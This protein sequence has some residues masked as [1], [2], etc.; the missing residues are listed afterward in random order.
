MLGGARSVDLLQ[1][2]SFLLQLLVPTMVLARHVSRASRPWLRA[3]AGFACSGI[4][5]WLLN[6]LFALATDL[7]NPLL[8]LV[9][10]LL[11]F[12]SVVA[13]CWLAL[14]A[15]AST[16]LF[17]ACSGYALQNIAHYVFVM[18]LLKSGLG[19]SDDLLEAVAFVG[20]YGCAF[21][22]LRRPTASHVEA[23]EARRIFSA[24]LLTLFFTVVLSS[25]VPLSADVDILY[26]LYSVGAGVLILFMQ[27]GLLDTADATSERDVFRSELE[28]EARRHKLAM[29]SVSL[30]DK[31]CHDLK[32]LVFL[33]S[34]KGVNDESVAEACAAIDAYDSLPTT[35]DPNLDLVLAEK[36]LVCSGRGIDLS[37]MVDGS[38][39]S[40]LR[41][42]DLWGLFGSVFD[43]SLG[44]LAVDDAEPWLYVRGASREGAANLHVE[45]P[46]RPEAHPDRFAAY[47][48]V[49]AL[50]HGY[51]GVAALT[52]E[53]GLATLDVLLL[54]GGAPSSAA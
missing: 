53:G 19:L 7:D 21:V 32:H 14:D 41:V 23:I 49:R 20:T 45:W 28:L 39:F 46:C 17:F 22:A 9:R 2:Y 47:E 24:C 48:N 16:A 3:F 12:A 15:P 38:A 43:L 54:R 11:A 36:A 35:G 5:L 18:L 50:A 30:I 13:T 10:Y 44:T 31:K 25:M 33:L 34:E 26:C 37:C 40:F 27:Y 42:D 6:R 52:A 29:E 51:D 8:V 1:I 4:A